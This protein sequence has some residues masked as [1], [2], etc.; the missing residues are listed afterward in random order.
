MCVLFALTTKHLHEQ[1][2]NLAHDMN[3][4]T[5][6]SSLSFMPLWC[7]L[8]HL[9]LFLSRLLPARSLLVGSLVVLLNE[10]LVALAPFPPSSFDLG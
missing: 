1:L 2:H 4:C 7:S 5:G 10:Q 6:M 8:F 3:H 9:F